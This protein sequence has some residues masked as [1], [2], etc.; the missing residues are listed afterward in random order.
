MNRPTLNIRWLA[1][2]AAM[3]TL[4]V[5]LLVD[6]PGAK[7]GPLT[8]QLGGIETGPGYQ[9]SLYFLG[10]AAAQWKLIHANDPPATPGD[11]TPPPK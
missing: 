10:S 1:M 6:A 5:A 4:L 3:A 7:A 2:P 9:F 11:P 8:G